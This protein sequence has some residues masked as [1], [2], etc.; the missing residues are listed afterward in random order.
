MKKNA[1]IRQEVAARP[2]SVPRRN[3][4]R[5]EDP[6]RQSDHCSWDKTNRRSEMEPGEFLGVRRN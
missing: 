2:L 6:D 3:S 1:S 4:G 5:D